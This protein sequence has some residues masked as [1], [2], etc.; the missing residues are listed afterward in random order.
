MLFVIEKEFLSRTISHFSTLFLFFGVSNN[1][2]HCC[3][4]E[5]RRK[6]FL[7]PEELPEGY[8]VLH[9]GMSS[10]LLQLLLIS[11][12]LSRTI[13]ITTFFTPTVLWHTL[14]SRGGLRRRPT[15]WLASSVTRLSWRA[16]TVL[17]MPWSISYA[18]FVVD[19]SRES[20]WTLKISW[21]RVL[22]TMP[23]ILIFLLLWRSLPLR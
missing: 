3:Y 16:I 1:V 10:P 19:D 4:Q 22:P 13:P 5:G 17:L 8:W 18:I 23:M 11:C 9:W 12:R 20:L 2:Y 6:R 15:V 14:L 7:R 21:T